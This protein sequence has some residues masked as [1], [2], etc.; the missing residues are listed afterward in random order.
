MS[1]PSSPSEESAPSAAVVPAVRET[2]RLAFAGAAL[3]LVMVSAVSLDEVVFQGAHAAAAASMASQLAGAVTAA[4]LDPGAIFA[5][6]SPGARGSGPLQQTKSERV[7]AKINPPPP[8]PDGP[9]ERVLAS[10]RERPVEP[11]LTAPGAPLPLSPTPPAFTGPSTF[12]PGPAAPGPYTPAPIQL[13]SLS[14]TPP[15]GGPPGDG[16]T[17]PDTPPNGPPGGPPNTPPNTPNTPPLSPVPE[18]AAWLL[19]ILAVSGVGAALRRARSRGRTTGAGG[20]ASH[21]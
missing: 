21:A 9:E 6:R 17:P 18:P 10:L 13:S 4:A 15:G 3:L 20:A 1:R 7:L 12:A 2:R 16:P 5:A 8:G 11:D 19:M 14:K